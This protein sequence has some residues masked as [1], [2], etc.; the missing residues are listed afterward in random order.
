[1]Q[2]PNL[3]INFI[4]FN[5]DCSSL[6]IGTK[7]GYKLFSLNSVDKLDLIYESACRFKMFTTKTNYSKIMF[8][9]E[10][11]PLLKGSSPPHS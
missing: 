9:P 10:M 7:T 6:A 11:S 3:D 8:L 5:Q 2:Q 1:M 4:N